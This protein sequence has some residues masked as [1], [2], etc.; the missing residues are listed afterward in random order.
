[1]RGLRG[2]KRDLTRSFGDARGPKRPSARLLCDIKLTTMALR[3]HASCEVR[4]GRRT[5]PV[6][7][8]EFPQKQK[9]PLEYDAAQDPDDAV[10]ATWLLYATKKIN[11]R[12]RA[13]KARQGLSHEIRDRG[14]KASEKAQPPL[15]ADWQRDG[16]SWLWHSPEGEFVIAPAEI[17]GA[18]QLTYEGLTTLEQI[19]INDPVDEL[20]HWA[21]RHFAPGRGNQESKSGALMSAKRSSIQTRPC[22]FPT[23]V[24]R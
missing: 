3:V 4:I 22:F 18:Y 5:M 7:C 1:M 14:S 23:P 16:S 10:A 21:Q 20:K 8:P 11:M 12:A 15:E 13:L 17:G 2:E 24:D 19:R 6:L 9:S